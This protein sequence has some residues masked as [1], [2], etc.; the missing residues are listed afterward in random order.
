MP[1]HLHINIRQVKLHLADC[2][3]NINHLSEKQ[4]EI[5]RTSNSLLFLLLKKYFFM[6]KLQSQVLY[7]T[8]DFNQLNHTSSCHTGKLEGSGLGAPCSPHMSYDGNN[9]GYT[10][11][12]R[13]WRTLH[14]PSFIHSNQTKPNW[15]CLRTNTNVDRF[16]GLPLLLGPECH[17]NYLLLLCHSI[18]ILGQDDNSSANFC[19][20]IIICISRTYSNQSHQANVPPFTSIIQK[21]PHYRKEKGP[22]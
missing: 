21:P 15:K 17:R 2:N 3:E 8:I 1:F 20:N 16:Y 10:R 13:S 12:Y 9:D 6:S 7:R 22:L 14:D 4:W 19:A 11:N 18:F 5:D